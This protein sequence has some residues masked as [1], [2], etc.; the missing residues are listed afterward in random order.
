VCLCVCVY[1]KGRE[2]IKRQFQHN[3]SCNSEVTTIVKIVA[4]KSSQLERNKIY[5]A[6]TNEVKSLEMKPFFIFQQ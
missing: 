2:R 5:K 6:E 4:I 1:V 3:V